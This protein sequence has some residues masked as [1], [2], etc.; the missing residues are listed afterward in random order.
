M[1]D[2]QNE[3]SEAEVVDLARARVRL[4]SRPEH[5]SADSHLKELAEINLLLD[6]GLS[7]E[8]RSRL[9][10]L[11]SAAR[12]DAFILA[13]A[14]LALSLALEMHG[15]YQKSLQSVAMYDDEA[16]CKNLPADICLKLRVQIAIA[17]NYCGDHPRAVASLQSALKDLSDEQAAPVYTAL[18]RIYRSIHESAIAR[19]F[20]ERALNAYRQTGDWRGLSEAYFGIALAN[21]YEGKHEP[22][23]EQFQQALKII[24]DHPATFLLGKVYSNMAGVCWHI[25][26]PKDGIAYLEKAIE[27]YEHSDHQM[28]AAI[29]HNNLGLNLV[30][31][32]QWERAEE[33]F[34]R[35]LSLITEIDDRDEKIPMAF[36]SLGELCILR[37]E[38]NEARDYLERAVALAKESGNKWYAGRTLRTMAHC[39]LAT[40]DYDSALASAEEA[41]EMGQSISDAHSIWESQLL[42]AESYLGQG[43]AA[44]CSAKLN[45]V[46][47][48]LSDSPTAIGLSGETQ[49]VHGLLALAKSDA[50]AATQHFGR[51][52]SIFEL[53][54]DR[55]R[56]GR[57]HFD[58]GRAYILAQSELAAEHLSRAI[59]IFR[60]LGA[61]HYLAKAE[62]ARD[63]YDRAPHQQERRR[64]AAIQ[65]ITLRLAEAVASRA[66]LLREFAA[67]VR[68]ETSAKRVLILEPDEEQKQRVVVAHGY[69]GDEL[70]AVAAEF[71]AVADSGA[72]ERFAKRNDI[73]LIT[74]KSTN[75]LPATVL[76]SPANGA[77][78][79]GGLTL[80]P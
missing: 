13:N 21:H 6:R 62:S 59:N 80:A 78:L 7:V 26:R 50:P 61:Q 15:D 51:C 49:R 72:R 18:A 75:S 38:L 27:Y 16:A 70:T 34:N 10:D 12:S 63:E 43:N 25:K 74:L 48:H 53:L 47:E 24:G 20:S 42:L 44:A 54:G 4:R 29:A 17:R 1:L 19:D 41:L 32:G 69:E 55:Y 35:S 39:H 52:V 65:L 56:T 66:L 14:R 73:K 77:E 64:D 58:L 40:E 71:A 46:S 3:L 68:Q 37:G 60:E 22:A 9:T 8:A 45:E 76:I 33:S 36:D 67:I 5:R 79:S 31:V 11:M 30:L 23:L 2:N 28:M 57:A